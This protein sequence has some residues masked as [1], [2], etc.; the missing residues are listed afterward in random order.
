MNLRP[1]NR[2]PV[3]I[4]MVPFDRYT[5]FP[6]SVDALIKDTSYPFKL[7]IIEGNAPESVRLDLDDRRRK[8]K[9]IRIIYSDHPTRMAEAF[10]LGL[11]HIRTR[12]AVLMHNKLRVT[13]GWLSSLVR[14]TQSK[15]GVICPY[16]NFTNGMPFSFLHA[17]L[18]EKTLLDELG[19]FDES[20]GTPF[21]GV[22]LENR[23]KAKKVVLH[24]DPG[25]VLEYQSSK[26][27]LKNA[28]RKLFQHQWN[29]P[30]ALQTLSYVKQKWGSA[31]EEAKYL[32]WLAKK[33][34]IGASKPAFSIPALPLFSLAKL[35]H[36][37]HRV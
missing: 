34:S 37:L 7:L 18:I 16:I 6:K 35:I 24:R 29:D 36:V 15:Q 32:A 5:E 21:W 28:D 20:V 27:L 9:N 3:T 23:L 10:N 12:H 22:D 11:V 17:F 19:L 8:H 33:R 1:E 13:P 2:E 14:E 30:H 4:V 31:P 26:T 25:S